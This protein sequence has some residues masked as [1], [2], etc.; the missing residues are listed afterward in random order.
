[1]TRTYLIYCS[2]QSNRKEFKDIIDQAENKVLS[3]PDEFKKLYMYTFNFAKSTG[4]KSMDVEVS[5]TIYQ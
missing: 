4:Q 3:S 2:Q 5:R 1:V